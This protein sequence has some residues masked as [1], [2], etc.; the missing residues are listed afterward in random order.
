MRR[1]I[2]ISVFALAMTGC[3]DEK[4]DRV[5]ARCDQ[6]AADALRWAEESCEKHIEDA[7]EQFWKDIEKEIK[8]TFAEVGCVS[9]GDGDFEYDCSNTFLCPDEGG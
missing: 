7:L 6:A 4:L 8:H 3:I 1:L 9:V 2:V 5:E